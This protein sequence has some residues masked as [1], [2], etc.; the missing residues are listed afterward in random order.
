MQLKYYICQNKVIAKNVVKKSK[1]D[2]LRSEANI[3][4]KT[5][6]ANIV[7]LYSMVET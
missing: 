4:S 3:L 5:D 2:H 7:K 6:H 1:M